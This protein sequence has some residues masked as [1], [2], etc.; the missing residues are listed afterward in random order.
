MCKHDV[1]HNRKYITYRNAVA[2]DE[3]TAMGSINRN[4][5][6]LRTSVFLRY[7]RGHKPTDRQTH[8]QTRSLQYC[9]LYKIRSGEQDHNQDIHVESEIYRERI[10]L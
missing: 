7:L 5:A 1:I 2:K 4:V 3:A 9:A 8:G 6:E 10:I